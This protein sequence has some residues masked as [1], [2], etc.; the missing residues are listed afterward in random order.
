MPLVAFLALAAI[1]F[2]GAALLLWKG[3]RGR[4]AERMHEAVEQHRAT[5]AEAERVRAR[6]D[7]ASQR[8]QASQQRLA[9]AVGKLSSAGEER[10]TEGEP[11]KPAD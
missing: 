2:V 9:D 8:L 11:D 4:A 1:P 3:P 5:R 10:P 6:L 7:A